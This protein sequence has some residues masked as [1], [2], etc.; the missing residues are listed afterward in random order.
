MTR[1]IVAL[2]LAATATLAAPASHAAAQSPTRPIGIAAGVSVPLSDAVDEGSGGTNIGSKVGYNLLATVGFAPAAF[3][4]ALRVDLGYTRLGSE[5]RPLLF[6]GESFG[7]V[8]AELG[9]LSGTIN[10]V[11]QPTTTMMSKPYF[12]G[13][14]GVYQVK[15][16]LELTGAEF[17]IGGKANETSTNV[18]FN[19]GGGL[20]FGMGGRSAFLEARYHRVLNDRRCGDSEQCLSRDA[21]AFVPI[22]FG[23]TF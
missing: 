23:F 1:T 10:G 21:T 15:Q 4:I 8:S 13:G 16:D 3:P 7:D 5:T 17:G 18:G 12:I 11:L 22:S 20:R 14:L 19:V 9:V 6:D 2:A